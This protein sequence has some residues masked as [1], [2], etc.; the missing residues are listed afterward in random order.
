MVIVEN[1]EF[2][3]VLAVLFL[4]G[5]EQ[6]GSPAVPVSVPVSV[7]ARGGAERP[8]RE[9]GAPARAP[10]PPPAARCTCLS[11]SLLFSTPPRGFLLCLYDM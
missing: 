7:L 6:S 5:L 3:V 9:R 10:L 1:V 11:L 4:Q 8:C 2:P